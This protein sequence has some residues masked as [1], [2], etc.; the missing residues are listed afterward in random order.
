MTPTTFVG[1]DVVD[2]DVPLT[3]GKV[4]DARFLAR[5]L[6]DV[7]LAAVHGAADPN[8]ELWSLW[9]CKEAAFKTATKVRGSPPIFAH[10]AFGVRLEEPGADRRPRAGR[11]VYEELELPVMVVERRDVLHAVSYAHPRT[12]PLRNEID[13]GLALLDEPAAS[14]NA[15]LEVLVRHLSPRE[16]EPVHS[17]ESAAVRLAARSTLAGA[18][19]VAEERLEIVCAPGSPGRRPPAVLLDGA[20]TTADVS[21]SHHGRWIAWAV[22]VESQRARPGNPTVD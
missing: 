1:N 3:R 8:R 2:L 13:L 20:S 10:A 16:A 18:M 4:E 7:E 14:W 12:L 9:A 15:P 6:D 19:G 22:H 5:I 11:V 21:L 17:R